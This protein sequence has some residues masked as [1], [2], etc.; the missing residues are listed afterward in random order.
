MK[1]IATAVFA[2]FL[3]V[4]IAGASEAPKATAAEQPNNQDSAKQTQTSEATYSYEAQGGDSYSLIARKAVQTYGKKHNVKLSG[5]QIVFAETNLTLTAGSPLLSKG[6]KVDV[7]ESVVK[8]W[9][10]KAGS[11]SKTAEAAWETYAQYA[12][13]NTDGI[14]EAR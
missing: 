14:G 12:D 11:L 9:V 1:L 6:Q 13:F 3:G 4:V 2:L 7:K 5:A 8:S 10:E